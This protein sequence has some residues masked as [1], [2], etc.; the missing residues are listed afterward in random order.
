MAHLYDTL[1][2]KNNVAMEET[3]QFGSFRQTLRVEIDASGH[4]GVLPH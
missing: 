4:D 1:E 2:E 3:G